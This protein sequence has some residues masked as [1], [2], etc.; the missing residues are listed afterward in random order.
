MLNL[1]EKEE[2]VLELL[3]RGYSNEKIGEVI[4][5]QTETVSQY[6]TQLYDK[7]NISSKSKK[8]NARVKAAMLYWKEVGF[9]N[10]VKKRKEIEIE[11]MR[12]SK[13]I[14]AENREMQ[15]IA[16]D[17]INALNWVLEE[18]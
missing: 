12:R 10:K 6:I 15:M 8:T 3:S 7:L 1:T 4:C 5:V 16:C 2:K 11:I 17:W 14:A 9:I 18:Q 13:E